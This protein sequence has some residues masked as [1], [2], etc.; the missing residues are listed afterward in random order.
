MLHFWNIRIAKPEFGYFNYGEAYLLET[1]STGKVDDIVIIT[2]IFT[3]NTRK[4]TQVLLQVQKKEGHDL[5][6]MI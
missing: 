1:N 5:I 4:R 2:W 6:G 3:L